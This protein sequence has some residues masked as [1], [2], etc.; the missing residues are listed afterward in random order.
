MPRGKSYCRGS[1]IVSAT[2]EG[3][4]PLA[5]QR[6]ALFRLV[7]TGA[8]TTIMPLR[9]EAPRSPVIQHNHYHYV[10]NTTPPTQTE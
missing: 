9:S 6:K 2:T 10:D 3:D 5:F 7:A 1:R 8:S 4:S